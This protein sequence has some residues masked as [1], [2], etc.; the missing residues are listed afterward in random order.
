MR[1]WLWFRWGM[2]SQFYGIRSG[3]RA[4][5]QAANRAFNRAL[6]L[7]P[8]LSVARYKRG[9]LYWRELHLLPAAIEDFTAIWALY[10][11]ALFMRGMAHQEL[12]DYPRA[13]E[14]LRLFLKLQPESKW[15][16]NAARQLRLIEAIL[17][18]MPPQLSA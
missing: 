2:L 18:D 1:A 11:E 13:A 12:H 9:L 3:Q 6:T 4:A 7:N 16:D 8:K 10:P 17:A 5:F 14:D 15:A